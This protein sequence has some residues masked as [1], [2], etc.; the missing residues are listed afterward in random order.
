MSL[1]R[2]SFGVPPPPHS[3]QT[4]L[5][6]SFLTVGK[7]EVMFINKTDWDHTQG[8]VKSLPLLGSGRGSRIKDKLLVRVRGKARTLKNKPTTNVDTGPWSD[9]ERI[10]LHEISSISTDPLVRLYPF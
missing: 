5:P 6:S 3:P 10:C 7:Q 4:L 8:N 2:S 9:L 1:L